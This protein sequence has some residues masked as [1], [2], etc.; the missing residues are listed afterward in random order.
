MKKFVHIFL[1][2][3]SVG[4]CEAKRPNLIFLLTDD[5]RAD[6]LSCAGHP[7]LK[8]PNLDQ[9]AAEGVRFENHYTVAPICMPSRVSL[10]LGQYQRTHKVGFSGGSRQ[11][12]EAQWS[13]SYPTLLRNAGYYTGFIGKFGVDKY[14]FKGQ[15]AEHF[16]FWKAHDGWSKF[17]PKERENTQ[18]YKDYPSDIITSIMGDSMED[19]LEQAPEDQPFCLSVSFSAPHNSVATSMCAEGAWYMDKPANADPRLTEHPIYGSLYR[20][21]EVELPATLDGQPEKYLPTNVLD[22]ENGRRQCYASDYRGHECLTEHYYR[23]A[24]LISGVDAQVGR[25]IAA[26]K[27]KGVLDNT[28]ILFSSD[29]GLLLGDYN[30]GGKGL[31]YDLTAKVPM[32]LY[33]PRL[34]EAQQG[35]VIAAPTLSVDVAPTLLSYA[36]IEIPNTMQ[37]EVMQPVVADASAGRESVF[38]ESVFGLRG[39]PFQQ[40]IRDERWKYISYYRP[41]KQAEEIASGKEKQR[42]QYSEDDL[43]F[44]GAPLY[45]QL[46]DLEKDPGETVNLAENPE[47]QAV[48]EQLRARCDDASAELNASPLN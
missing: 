33:D 34:P 20:D 40:G 5:Q 47:Y 9:L 17:F 42:Y 39:N 2:V 10:L 13:Q 41:E 11:V 3:V 37:G 8:T 25:L 48:L 38:I 46:F 22:P 30:H 6:A 18:L 4:W 43:K 31:L 26:L 7:F 14:Y 16:D 36:G 21:Q 29:N 35:Q 15:S 12:S 27:K 19:F 28:I 32:L 45:E 44:E 1:L 24:Q 23:Y